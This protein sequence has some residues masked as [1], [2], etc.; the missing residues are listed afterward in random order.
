MANYIPQHFEP[1]AKAV[2]VKGVANRAVATVLTAGL[3]AQPLMSPLAAIA[4]PTA[5]NGDATK[6]D[7]AIENTVATGNQAVVKTAAQLAEESAK[8]LKD[9]QA[10]YDAAQKKADAVG[11]SQKQAQRQKNQASRA[12]TDNAAEQNEA[13]AAALQ[14]KID[15]LKAAVDKAEQQQKK[16]GDL[17]DQ[18]DQANKSVEDKTQALKD[19]KAKQDEAKKALDDAQAKLKAMGMDEYEAAKKAVETRRPS[20]MTPIRPLLLHRPIW[21]R[22]R[23]PRPAP[24]RKSRIPRRL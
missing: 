6:G 19:A 24:S 11:Q 15:E 7:S 13:E 18:L 4:A 1:R 22:P 10:A 14:E 5:D 17:N 2:N 3:I 21:T 16:L 23:L 8:Q 12:V 20:S 9:A